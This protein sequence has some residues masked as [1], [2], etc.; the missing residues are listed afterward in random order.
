MHPGNLLLQMSF[1]PPESGAVVVTPFVASETHRK[2]LPRMPSG[3]RTHLGAAIALG[4]AALAIYGNS[5]DAGFVL[6]NQE[7][8]RQARLYATSQTSVRD[9]LSHDYWWPSWI[10]G[11]YRP[12][13][14]LSY[15]F[16]YSVLGN[17]DRPLGYHSIN[18]FLHWGN[19]VLVYCLLLTLVGDTRTAFFA[20]L[21]FLTHPISTEA[22]T[23]IVGRSDLFATASVLGGL[24]LYIRGQATGGRQRPMWLSAV[25]LTMA[26]GCFFKETATV[27]CGLIVLYDLA[28]R[29]DLAGG[30]S[31]RSVARQLVGFALRGWIVF[32]PP[33]LLFWAARRWVY[34]AVAPP[35]V[36]FTENHLVA[37]DF[38]TARLTAIKLL[39][40]SL[41]LLLWPQWLCWDYSVNEVPIFHWTLRDWADWQAVVTLGVL[42]GILAAS[43]RFWR[44]N[45]PLFFFIGFFF[46]AILPTSNLIVLIPCV[47]G[48][49]FLY[50]PHVAFAAATALAARTIV[51]QAHSSTGNRLPTSWS[52]S[53]SKS[54]P[55]GLAEDSATRSRSERLARSRHPVFQRAA[56]RVVWVVLGVVAAAYGAR[57]YTRNFDWHDDLSMGTSAVE[58]CPRSF[59]VHY[60]FAKALF[61]RGPATLDRAIRE[62]ERAQEILAASAPPA[63]SVP[64]YVLQDLGVYYD[65]KASQAAT[66]AGDDGSGPESLLWRTRAA[67]ALQ[68][69]VDWYRTAN[70]EHKRLE[71]ERGRRPEEIL[72][73]GVASVATNL[74]LVYAKLGKP[75]EAIAAFLQARHLA[76]RDAGVH[77]ALSSAYAADGQTENAIVSLLQAFLFDQSRQSIWPQLVSLYQTVD[78]D[79]CVFT[80]VGDEY[81]YN[82]QCPIAREHVCAA[83]RRQVEIYRDAHLWADATDL[84]RRAPDCSGK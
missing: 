12:L 34:R 38:V 62:A 65:A 29:L 26:T 77:E 49:R 22:V 58:T 53:P 4:L 83:Y 35:P 8:L 5:L 79:G 17:A 82:S 59:R 70:E 84:A 40:K 2:G 28:F 50:L 43:V 41:W 9:I 23:N 78:P 44:R 15:W 76:P 72:D 46:V 27:L 66:S 11:S 75:R 39:G 68:R 71:L 3:L 45:R 54:E 33:L 51:R 19:A 36:Y 63:T 42:A 6:D 30:Q 61:E 69:A 31:R 18:L 80:R 52:R 24:L 14:T 7:M 67:N 25:A 47:L 48:E 32:V 1:V 81:H 74:G 60:A 57:T 16:N 64:P 21:L 20:A 10:S 37:A 55:V 13:S 56:G 73:I